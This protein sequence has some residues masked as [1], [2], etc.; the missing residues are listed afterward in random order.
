M[1]IG[2]ATPPIA[3]H[4]ILASPKRALRSA[5]GRSFG[6]DPVDVLHHARPVRSWSMPLGAG[7]P[8]S[9][10]TMGGQA[11]ERNLIE[12]IVWLRRTPTPAALCPE[13]TTSHRPGAA[14]EGA[15]HS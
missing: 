6:V 1:A 2:G 5:R 10:R 13:R 8:S 11:A 7:G 4:S 3:V 12:I 9:Y 15:H 14:A